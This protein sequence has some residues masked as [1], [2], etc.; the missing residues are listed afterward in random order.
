[1]PITPF[2]LGPGVLIKSVLQERFS[3]TVFAFSQGL[4]DIQPVFV[5]LLGKGHLHGFTHTYVGAILLAIIATVLGKP[6]CELF[7]RF[8]NKTPEISGNSVLTVNA[9]I[10]WRVALVSSLIGTYSHV[11]LDSFMHSDIH[12]FYPVSTENA[13]FS[14][15]SLTSLHLFCIISGAIGVII[16]CIAM[17]IKKIKI[18]GSVLDD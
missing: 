14:Q 17:V 10:S 16:M 1:M 15:I 7:L 5:I 9:K 18:D 3:L 8:W 11:I 12:P 2:H 4:I 6:I 13:L